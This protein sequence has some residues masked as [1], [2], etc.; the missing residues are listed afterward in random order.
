MSNGN[1]SD[2]K[3]SAFWFIVF[4]V[5]ALF[6]SVLSGIVAFWCFGAPYCTYKYLSL[7]KWQD[8]ELIKNPLDRHFAS[9]KRQVVL[10][11]ESGLTT[12]GKTIFGLLLIVEGYI[13]LLALF[14]I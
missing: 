2:Q 14:K 13:G 10:S 3:H 8:P 1:L 4:V 9:K 11:N 6:N 12:L 7:Y 5:M